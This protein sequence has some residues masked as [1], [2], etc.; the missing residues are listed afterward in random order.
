M[1]TTAGEKL[2]KLLLAHGSFEKVEGA[3]VRWYEHKKKETEEGGYVTKDWL[4][5][6][7]HWTKCPPSNQ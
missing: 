3:L 5:K 7:K 2:R 6:E 4:Q 1:C